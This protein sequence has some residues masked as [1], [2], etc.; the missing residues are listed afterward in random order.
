M[1]RKIITFCSICREAIYE[2]EEMIAGSHARCLREKG[3]IIGKSQ[4]E[5]PR[6]LLPDPFGIGKR[7]ARR[8]D[9]PV[10][11][12]DPISETL[13]FDP[14]EVLVRSIEVDSGVEREITE[15]RRRLEAKGYRP[16]IIEKSAILAREWLAKMT[17]AFVPEELLAVPDA[18]KRAVMHVM[19][20]AIRAAEHWAD[21][22]MGTSPPRS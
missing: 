3:I 5:K 16:G 15:L 22:M 18:R 2:E 6:I 21:V 7:L 8:L 14:P 12:I 17:A 9:L 13:R 20:H 1:E 19:P 4:E 10:E 11:P